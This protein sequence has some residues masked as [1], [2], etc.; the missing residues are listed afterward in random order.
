MKNRK[1][2]VSI[3]GIITITLAFI[4][5]M[6]PIHVAATD[7]SEWYMTVNGVLDTDNYAL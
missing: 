4:A 2:L 1:K 3:I 6:I 7:P 5:S